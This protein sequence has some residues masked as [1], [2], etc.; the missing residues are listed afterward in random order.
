[1]LLARVRALDSD[2]DLTTL[3]VEQQLATISST[4]INKTKPT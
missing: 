1:L 4:C 3:L 2:S